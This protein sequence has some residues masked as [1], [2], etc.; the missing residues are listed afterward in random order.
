MGIL[1]QIPKPKFQS[2]KETQKA[3]PKHKKSKTTETKP[4]HTNHHTSP[5]KTWQHKTPNTLTPVQHTHKG[6]IIQAGKDFGREKP[7]GTNGQDTAERGHSNA[8][9]H[10]MI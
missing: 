6:K 8:K 2:L 10:G 7:E 3:K 5:K 4:K 9:K 1:K